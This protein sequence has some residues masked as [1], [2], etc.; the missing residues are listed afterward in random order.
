MAVAHAVAWI[1]S[2]LTLAGTFSWPGSPPS[3][4]AADL[5][6]LDQ[7]T[8]VRAVLALASADDV[9]ARELL[10]PMLRDR[11]PV[12]RE[13]AARVLARRGAPEAVEAATAWVAGT[14]A[15]DRLLGL[16]VLRDAPT[17][18]A[19]ARRAAERAT[20][21]GDLATRGQALEVLSGHEPAASFAAI[22]AALGDEHRDVRAR[23]ARTLG[24]L[25]DRRAALP[26]ISRLDDGDRLVRVEVIVALGALGE[27]R[28]L[29][30]LLRQLDAPTV[31][32]RLPAVDALAA[33][34]DPAAVPALLR[35]AQRRPLDEVGRRAIVALGE[36][37]TPEA[38]ES[39]RA[40][41]RETDALDD[42]REALARAGARALPAVLPLL[43]RELSEGTPLTAP[44]AANLLGALGDRRATP[45]LAAAVD[46]RG[47]AAV[48]AANALARLGD[49]AAVPALLRAAGARPS[50][51][52]LREAALDALAALADDRAA[53]GA[54]A[55]LGDPEATVRAAAARAAAT[56]GG[57]ALAPALAV[58]LGD[59]DARVRREA[60]RALA[61]VAGPSQDVARAIIAA[62]A[63][64]ELA[65]DDAALEALGEALER[66]I[67]REDAALAEQAFLDAAPGVA[68]ATR[69]PLARGLA[70]AHGAG[71]LTSR[72]VIDALVSELAGDGRS[73]I[74]AADA[75]GVARPLAGQEEAI[76]AAFAFAEPSVAARLAPALARS[77]DG[78]RQ[79]AAT[80]RDPDAGAPRRAAAAWALAG[81]PEG[82]AALREASA[83]P[84]APVA[85]NARAALAAG[86]R[87]PGG[88]AAVRLVTPAGE[89]WPRRWVTV[90]PA[91]GAP[92]WLLTDLDGRAR[93]AAA[94]AGLAVSVPTE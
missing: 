45:W 85:A 32:L 77:R 54:L 30:A 23:A 48:A 71:D 7:G 66:S 62:L 94:A 90:T 59:A 55:A 73:A 88:W 31:E 72:P 19:A 57:P 37:A 91:N 63:R 13:T 60:S 43:R 47:P 69:A 92:V 83:S 8:R 80:V 89:P 76:A 42:V 27:P 25:R 75:L 36:L 33:L 9:L 28:A 17:L 65:R 40:M 1:L 52:D 5:A 18:T 67:R 38:L 49:D 78:Q 10:I 50:D 29:P 93:F 12:V 22:L 34:G 11:E 81:V 4:P 6:A 84:E 20:R 14:T 15:R 74:A 2:G 56:C 87:G 44:L 58:R 46:A 68:R 51:A 35:V 21:D 26:L 3:G 61:R 41:S 64:G 39:L 70:A 16:H 79:L 24:L 82:R 53:E 86:P